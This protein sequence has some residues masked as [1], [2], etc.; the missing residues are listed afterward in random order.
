VP[1][2]TTPR[3][4][5]PARADDGILYT[6][7]VATTGGR[8]YPLLSLAGEVTCYGGAALEGNVAVEL[9]LRR[10]V[11][12]DAVVEDTVVLL[13]DDLVP[14]RTILSMAP[15]EGVSEVREGAELR[16]RA[17]VADDA[18]AE[19]V[20]LYDLR[21]GGIALV[22]HAARPSAITLIAHRLDPQITADL[23]VSIDELATPE[24]W[25]RLHDRIIAVLGAAAV[26]TYKGELP[27]IP[28]DSCA[29]IFSHF[30]PPERRQELGAGTLSAGTLSAG[31]ER[32]PG[33]RSRPA[34]AR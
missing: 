25:G 31:P 17:L 33:P 7:Y 16:G 12:P 8:T 1:A 30:P 27:A 24:D 6:E 26:E 23:G 13:P 10:G 28:A 9:Y 14:R 21:D 5:G 3:A 18:A 11:S 19:A 15:G 34:R 29:E 20:L 2:A 32:R 22:V 4:S